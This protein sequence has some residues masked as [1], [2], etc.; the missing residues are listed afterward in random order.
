MLFLRTSRVK[1]VQPNRLSHRESRVAT[2]R[3]GS[4]QDILMFGT[5]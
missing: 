2:V 1:N 4:I 3:P 5:D